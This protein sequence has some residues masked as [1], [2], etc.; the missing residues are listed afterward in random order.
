MQNMRLTISAGRM[1]K[2]ITLHY[3]S[4]RKLAFFLV[5]KSPRGKRTRENWYK[6]TN[7]DLSWL[8]SILEEVMFHLDFKV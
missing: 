8:K 2:Y 5:G 6:F 7:R 1:T 3:P 4:K